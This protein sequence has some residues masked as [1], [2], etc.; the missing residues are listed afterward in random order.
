MVIKYPNFIIV[1]WLLWSQVTDYKAVT[2]VLNNGANATHQHT[3]QFSCW[4]ATAQ[5]WRRC[6][7]CQ[8][9][10]QWYP[11]TWSQALWQTL[12]SQPS[13]SAIGPARW[14]HKDP[15][16]ALTVQQD[17]LSITGITHSLRHLCVGEEGRLR[18][19]RHLQRNEVKAKHILFP[20]CHHCF[21]CPL[22][23]EWESEKKMWQVCKR[24]GKG[25]KARNGV[26]DCAGWVAVPGK[27]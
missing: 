8:W 10:A 21:F 25:V 27:M 12:V 5:E 13:S 15:F 2:V 9:L 20:S 17:F 4:S 6:V 14:Y 24:R 3:A 19:G 7:Q 23:R 1:I 16:N 18:K 11:S 22:P 26:Q